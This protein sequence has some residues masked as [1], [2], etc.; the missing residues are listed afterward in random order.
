MKKVIKLFPA[1]GEFA[2]NKD[3][4]RDIRIKKIE[5]LLEKDTHVILDFS[6]VTSATQSFMHAL[7]SGLIRKYDVDLF[8]ILL[9]QNCSSSIQGIIRIVV[10]YMLERDE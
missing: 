5:P 2:E 8:D 9:F 10:D 4:A 7:I 1:V 6:G 3:V